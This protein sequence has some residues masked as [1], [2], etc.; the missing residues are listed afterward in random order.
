MTDILL[1]VP[2]SPDLSS[3]FAAQVRR[4]PDAVA[5]VDGDVRLSYAQLDGISASLAAALVARGVRPGQSVAVCLPRSWQLVA[6]MLG[7][8]R[9][10]AVLVPVDAA[11][12]ADRIDTILADCACSAF[13]HAEAKPGIA[14]PPGAWSESID[15]LLAQG[16]AQR[17]APAPA[18][19]EAGGFCMLFYTSGTTGQPKGVEVR[20]EGI[21]RLCRPGYIDMRPGDRYASLSNPA[22]D[23]ISFEVW[24]PLLTGGCCVVW[25]DEDL[26][27]A[28]RFAARLV[29][30]RIDTLFI[31]VALF[32]AIVDQEP[33]CF[34]GMRQVLVGG[35]QL[36]A[37]A[38]KSW[39][40]ANPD[41]P[42]QLWNLYGPTE[43]TTFALAHHIPRGFDGTVVPIG[44]PLADTDIQLVAG[45]KRLAADGEVAELH[46]GGAG[47]AVGYHKLPAL[48]AE[49][50]VRLHWLDGGRALYYRTGDLVRRNAA[51]L[52]EYVGRTDRQVKVRGFRIEP[53]EVEQRILRHPAVR[54]AHVCTRRDAVGH[55]E[56]LAF[57]VAAP[58]LDHGAFDAHLRATLPHYMRP[59]RLFLVDGFPRTPNGK[60]DEQRMLAEAPQ[61][62]RRP[63][64]EAAQAGPWQQQVLELAQQV[65]AHAGLQ[66]EDDFI[67]SGGDS[68]KAL[69][70][71]FAALRQW[72]HDLPVAAIL[73]EPFA[74]LAE[75][76]A[77]SADGAA[78]VYP[79]APAPSDA[80]HAPAT[81]EQ[82]RLWFLQQQ[83]PESTAYNVPLAFRLDGPVDGD[84]LARA[85]GLLVQRHPALHTAFAAGPQSLQQ[86]AMPPPHD[87]CH[88]HPPG[89]FDESNWRAF[90]DLVFGA[91]FDLASP[92]LV[93]AH[94]LPLAAERG[95]LLLHIHHA[96]VDGWSLNLLF[97]DL[98]ALYAACAAGAPAP[99]P[100][101][102]LT[103]LEFA[104][105]QAA[106]FRQPEYAR[107][108]AA[109]AELH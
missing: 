64:A 47:L 19:V 74:A 28:R 63:A 25:R 100:L 27:D 88:R 49:R 16:S 38:V 61:P 44:T 22:F 20:A 87:V 2:Q 76:L 70:F 9:A 75:R 30:Q 26:Q 36:S 71:H 13:I 93:Q 62:W 65:L 11:S 85:I 66:P 101:P 14:L 35:E 102:A 12:P 77:R 55:H 79:E 89:H 82:Q 97:E 43:C 103:P 104:P 91:P 68:L 108:R 5:V 95:V 32:N 69:Q 15:A 58:Q 37:E 42:G 23:A 98:G 57:L 99:E 59:H 86:V 46:L 33:H 40:R 21:L 4:A 78:S 45:G 6:L 39:Y 60:L 67:G 53:G 24:V 54:R 52:I 106:W 73:R 81:A 34:A 10:G 1:A 18:S 80:D 29:A 3:A 107:Q 84:A 94:W 96:V 56:L 8:L 41:A 17:A 72:R 48:T 51:G 7:V 105:W 50:F 109:V 90:A 31:T 83:S 92:R